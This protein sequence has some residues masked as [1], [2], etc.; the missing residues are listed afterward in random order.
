MESEQQV[1]LDRVLHS[2][3]SEI[4]RLYWFQAALCF[5][6]RL[7][8]RFLRLGHC[9]TEDCSSEEQGNK[10][11]LSHINVYCSS[12]DFILLALVA[13]RNAPR[14]T[15]TKQKIPNDTD[16]DIITKNKWR[17]KEQQTRKTMC[18]SQCLSIACSIPCG[19]QSATLKE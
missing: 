2:R 16:D 14:L 7:M 13:G 4:E 6:A 8:A 12:K 19:V 10:A 1:Q 15:G 3:S 9:S 18:S 11:A 17:A 5:C